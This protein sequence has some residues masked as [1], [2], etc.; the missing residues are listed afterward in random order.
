[1][2]AVAALAFLAGVGSSSAFWVSEVRVEAPD[3]ALAAAVSRTLRVP[4]Q[5]SVFYPVTAIERQATSLPQVESVE[6]RRDL[7]RRLVV[8]ITRRLPVAA[9]AHEK[10]L[11]LVGADGVFTNLVPPGEKS[12][13]LPLWFGLPVEDPRPGGRLTAE[14]ATRVAEAMAAATDSG[15]ISGLAFD[16][17][18]P[19]NLRLT[20]KGVEG[21]LG[22]TDNLERKVG[23][24]AALLEELRRQGG[25]PAYIDVRVMD[26]PVWRPKGEATEP[27]PDAAAGPP[28][29]KPVPKPAK[30]PMP[31]AGA[32]QD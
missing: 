20:Y 17:S 1:M 6:V 18:Q 29:P 3:P 21:F 15:L 24:F 14:W 10:G 8:I 30:P 11:L 22:A 25:N 12:P 23:L 4:A 31:A 7:P 27:Q 32:P 13:K 2:L 19:L 26:R 9:V 28:V 5:T 16:C